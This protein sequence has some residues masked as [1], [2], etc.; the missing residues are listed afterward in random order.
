MTVKV[1]QT[2]IKLYSLMISVVIQVPM[3]LISNV[4]IQANIT[5]LKQH[6]LSWVLSL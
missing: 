4:R 5:F 6:R 1:I 3:E 2:E